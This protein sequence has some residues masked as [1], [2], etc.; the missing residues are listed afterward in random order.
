VS[1]PLAPILLLTD[2]GNEPWPSLSPLLPG[3]AFVGA[4]SR[5]P[6]QIQ[7]WPCDV[8]TTPGRRHP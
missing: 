3:G 4:P 1:A 7:N 6:R 5:L 2:T 8:I